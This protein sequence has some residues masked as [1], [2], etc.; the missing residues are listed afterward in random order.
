MVN[1]SVSAVAERVAWVRMKGGRRYWF[2]RR[3]LI[4]RPSFEIRDDGYSNYRAVP[5]V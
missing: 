1:Q 5:A 3:S 2:V 4:R